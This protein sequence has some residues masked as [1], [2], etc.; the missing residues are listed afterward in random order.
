CARA[1]VRSHPDLSPRP[2][3]PR[4]LSR[5]PGKLAAAFGPVPACLSPQSARAADTTIAGAGSSAAAPVYRTWAAE[6]AKDQGDTLAYEPVGSGAGMARIRKREVDFGASDV[7][8]S[9]ADLERDGLVTFPTVIT[10]VG[11]VAN[12]PPVPSNAMRLSGAVLARIFLG[13]IT[14][15]DAPEIKALNPSLAL[16]AQRIQLVVREDSSGTTFHY[17]D[18]LSHVSPAW[19]Q[20]R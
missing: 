16:P 17:T 9:K 8:A 14:Q 20:E 10:G 18:Y 4:P 7:I 19:K 3:P 1:R 2:R 5:L 13:T 15:W 12:L 11:P 6:Y